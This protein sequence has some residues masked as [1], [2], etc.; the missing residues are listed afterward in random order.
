MP[1]PAE[2]KRGKGSVS[3]FSSHFIFPGDTMDKNTDLKKPNAFFRNSQSLDIG[4]VDSDAE[5]TDPLIFYANTFDEVIVDGAP[6]INSTT[7][8]RIDGCYTAFTTFKKAPIPVSRTTDLFTG[9]AR[10]PPALQ[11]Q[12]S[13]T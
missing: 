5:H 1:V 12:W 9:I 10:H 8:E 3:H 4:I 11:Y 6:A 7:D 2:L 13:D